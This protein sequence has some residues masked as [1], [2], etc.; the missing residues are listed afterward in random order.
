MMNALLQMIRSCMGGDSCDYNLFVSL[1]APPA[2]CNSIAAYIE[3]ALHNGA[4]SDMCNTVTDDI[5]VIMLTRCCGETEDF[6]P[7]A[8]DAEAKCF[9]RDLFALKTCLLCNIGDTLDPYTHCHPTLDGIA[10]DGEREGGCYSAAIRISLSE[11][12][13]CPPPIPP[14]IP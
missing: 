8:E 14:A 9:L 10:F 7:M 3:E 11:I 2:I 4:D 12:S 1:G 13:C 5:I 6:D